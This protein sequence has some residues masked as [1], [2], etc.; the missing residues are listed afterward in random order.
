MTRRSYD[1]FCEHMDFKIDMMGI[2]LWTLVAIYLGLTLVLLG[3]G[4]WVSLALA[5]VGIFGLTVMAGG[6]EGLVGRTLFNSVNSFSL[7]AI[8]LFIFMG[9]FVICSGLGDGLY[10]G[11]SRWTSI[12]PGGLT[13]SNIIACAFFAATSGSSLATAATIGAVAYPEQTKRGYDRKLVMGSLAA[14]GTLGILIP[15]SSIMII[16]GSFVGESVGQLFI[17]GIIPGIIMSVTF[18]GWIMIAALVRPQWVPKRE[19]LTR[20]YFRNALAAFKDIW[21]VLVLAFTILGSI[22]LGFATP[23]ESAA[24]ATSMAIAFAAVKRRLNFQVFIAA[25]KGTIRTTSMIGF[26]VAGATLMAMAMSMMKVPAQIVAFIQDLGVSRMM[27]WGC[28]VLMYVV[29]GMFLEGVSMMLLTLPVIYPIL[30]SLG[31]GSLWFGIQMVV[32]VEMSL[33][34]PPVGLCLYVIHGVGGGKRMQDSIIG[35]IPFFFC[36]V[37]TLAAL[38]AF[39]ELITWLPSMMFAPSW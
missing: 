27:V 33:I 21:P 32:L 36:M 31:F 34:T 30:I 24:I 5:I 15:P 35:I 6:M 8:P 39:P 20:A 29:L 10:R 3:S 14:G 18:M 23:T 22:Y 12:I 13:H 19:K 28:V 4:M 7:V 37:A 1:E 25:L 9:E 38:T 2:D 26:I 16:Y 11:A 17:G